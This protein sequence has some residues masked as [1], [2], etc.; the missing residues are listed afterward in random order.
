MEIV[1]S[2]VEDRIVICDICG[3][4]EYLGEMSLLYGDKFACRKCYEEYYDTKC[5]SNRRVP[6][7]IEYDIQE[8]IKRRE[9]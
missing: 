5:T 8:E 3:Y 9:T 2:Q 1:E 7:R 6:S 4:P